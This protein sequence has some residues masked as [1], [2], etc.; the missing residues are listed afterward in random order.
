MFLHLSVSYSVHNGGGSAPVHAG[1]TTPRD[2]RQTLPPVPEA[3][4]REQIPPR[5]YTPWS[6]HTPYAVHAGR[7]GQQADGTHPTGMHAC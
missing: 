4:P 5:A 7:Y 6:R 2:Q 3:D 1:I